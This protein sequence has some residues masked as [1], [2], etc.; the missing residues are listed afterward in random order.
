MSDKSHL[1]ETAGLDVVDG[2]HRRHPGAKMRCR[3]I[4]RECLF[5]AKRGSARMRGFATGVGAKADIG[6]PPLT[7]L[8][9]MSTRPST[10]LADLWAAILEPH[11][12]T[13]TSHGHLRLRECGND[14][15][16]NGWERRLRRAA[17]VCFFSL[18]R[19]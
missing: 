18:L 12:A 5:W 4:D 10:T 11:T 7:Q 3:L 15:A 9:F 6:T 16:S 13:G 2:S 14:G 17:A 19:R 8:S 1:T